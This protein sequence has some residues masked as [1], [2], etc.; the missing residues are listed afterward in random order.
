[1]PFEATKDIVPKMKEWPF[2]RYASSSFNKCPH[3]VL[4]EMAGP[5][6][7]IHIDP[8]TEPV[9]LLTAPVPLHW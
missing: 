9:G 3:Q 7:K 8:K 1:M 6:I 5:P 2:K 4:P